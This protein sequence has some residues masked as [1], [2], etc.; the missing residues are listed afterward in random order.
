MEAWRG[1][2]AADRARDQEPAHADPALRAAAAAAAT[3]R[4]SATAA[5]SSTSARGRSSQ[6]V[7]ELK[8]LGERVLDLR[9][10]ALGAA[11][12]AEPERLVDEALV[13]FREGHRDVDFVFEP[14]ETCPCS[15]SIARASSARLI[16][17]LDNAVAACARGGTA[18]RR[19]RA[20]RAAHGLRSALD[21]ARLEIADNGAGMTPEVKARLFEPYFSTKARARASGSRSSRPSSPITTASSACA[22][23][24][25]AAAASSWSSRRARRPRS[26]RGAHGAY[27]GA[28]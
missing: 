25:R 11:R 9:A 21:V 19:A 26:R 23:T 6:Q 3:A 5:R 15:T 24:C 20:H 1:G 13:L 18:A 10:H 17:I 27:A 22:T 14:A 28:S 7:E 2:R 4:S 16:N 8:A 12:A